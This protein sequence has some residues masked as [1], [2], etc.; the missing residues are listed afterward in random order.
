MTTY[1][2][3]DHH[4]VARQSSTT[5]GICAQARTYFRDYG[6]RPAIHEV[7]WVP[8]V[9]EWRTKHRNDLTAQAYAKAALRRA[10]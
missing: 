7:Y 8:S 4:G 3:M 9:E 2:F 1:V 10:A 6:F 5:S